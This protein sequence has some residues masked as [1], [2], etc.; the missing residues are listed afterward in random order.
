MC[1]TFAQQLK[2]GDRGEALLKDSYPHKLIK[3]EKDLRYDF[4]CPATASKVEL[5]TDTY[6]MDKTPNFFM[7]KYSDLHSLK[8]GGPWRANQDNVD[9]FIYMFIND[10]TYYEFTDIPKLIDRLDEI[11]KKLRMTN[12]RNSSWTTGG[13]RIP[14]KD[15]EDLATIHTIEETN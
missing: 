8:L 14:R 6:K 10:N 13:Y 3:S 15:I 9:I 1:F 11:T 4:Y 2:V 7:E 5:K 12:I